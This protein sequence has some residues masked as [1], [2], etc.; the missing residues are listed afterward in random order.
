MIQISSPGQ[1]LSIGIKIDRRKGDRF[2]F[3]YNGVQVWKG[4][5]KI[6]LSPFLLTL[7][8]RM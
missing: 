2:I 7:E 5:E 6:N 1:G 4:R 8:N 3:Q